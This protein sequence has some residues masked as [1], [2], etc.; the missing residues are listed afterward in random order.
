MRKFAD[1]YGICLYEYSKRFYELV[2]VQR[3]RT[4]ILRIL[5]ILK[6]VTTHT[7]NSLR[8]RSEPPRFRN[9]ILEFYPL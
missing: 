7:A 3:Y 1:V 6:T 2:P 4:V 8:I 9:A 5:R